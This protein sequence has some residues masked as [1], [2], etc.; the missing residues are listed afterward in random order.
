M[1]RTCQKVSEASI[2]INE[3]TH[4]GQQSAIEELEEQARWLSNA[5]H[6]VNTIW[7]AIEWVEVMMM[8]MAQSLQ[9]QSLQ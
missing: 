2:A 8:H 3:Q 9:A 7:A 6:N 1:I 4:N 5:E